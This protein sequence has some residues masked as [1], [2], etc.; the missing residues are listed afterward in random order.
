M[1]TFFTIISGLIILFSTVPLAQQSKKVNP[2]DG[3][4]NSGTVYQIP[5]LTV[6]KFSYHNILSLKS[7][8]Q[9]SSAVFS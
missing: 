1:K 6:K 4:V 5:I 3:L 2:Y 9:L 8:F 7:Y